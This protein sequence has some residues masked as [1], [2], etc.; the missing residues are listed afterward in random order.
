MLYSTLQEIYTA[1]GGGGALGN[2]K[3]FRF[4][5]QLIKK[6]RINIHTTNL[7]LASINLYS[8]HCSSGSQGWVYMIFFFEGGWGGGRGAGGG[9]GWLGDPGFARAREVSGRALAMV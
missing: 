8:T 4:P 7:F 9:V 3:F 2:N 1:G 5:L 6:T